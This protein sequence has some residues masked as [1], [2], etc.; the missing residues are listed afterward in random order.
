LFVG[1]TALFIGVA[2]GG[3]DDA[4]QSTASVTTTQPT[5]RGETAPATATA[6]PTS[7]TTPTPSPTPYNG[8]IARL[9]IPRFKVDAPI[10]SLDLDASNTMQ[11]PKNEN[12]DVAWYYRWDKP[13][14]ANPDNSAAW[15]G[16]SGYDKPGYKGNSVFSAHIYYHEKPAPFQN[17]QK[18]VVGDDVAVVMDDGREYQYKVITAPQVIRLEDLTAAR[19]TE[20]IWPSNKPADKEWLT[21]F[22][23]GGDF[24]PV[25]REYYSRVIV[26]A[27]RTQ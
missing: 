11:T 10:E 1:V 14:R 16:I 25:S 9:K 6:S 8:L 15:A 24:D 18:L 17:V 2:C 26:V 20:V 19:M 22:S 21:L 27:E 3:D 12:V 7:T 23:C 13:G 4:K 5:Q